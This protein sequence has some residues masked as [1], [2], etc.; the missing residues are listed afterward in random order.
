MEHTVKDWSKK[1]FSNMDLKHSK[2]LN[3]PEGNILLMASSKLLNSCHETKY[4]A[5]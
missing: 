4:I 3:I 1:G 2:I 5:G